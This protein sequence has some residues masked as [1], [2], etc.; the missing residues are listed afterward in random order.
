MKSLK[1]FSLNLPEQKYHEY[2]AW[3]YSMIA[4]YAKEGFQS[5]SHLHEFS[6]PTPS[7]EFGSLF[8]SIITRGKSTLDEYIVSDVTAPDAEKKV[9]EYILS[10][11]NSKF[12]SISNE[13]FEEAFDETK[14]YGNRKFDTKVDQLSKYSEYYNTRASGKKVVSRSDW[15]EAI[16]MAKNFRSYAHIN[17]LFGTK[18]SKDVEYCYQLQLLTEIESEDGSKI[19]IKIMLDAVKVDHKAKTVQP[20]D[21]KTS[22]QPAYDFSENFI[23]YRYD[24]QASLYTFVLKKVLS[25]DNEYK[26]YTVLP[27]IFADISRSDKIPVTWTYDPNDD[28]QVNGLCYEINGKTYQYKNWYTLLSEILKYEEAKA[29]VP[30][31]VSTTNHNNLITALSK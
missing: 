29:V 22:F 20:I 17:D 28:S 12:E 1:E 4:K 5:L 6:K 30:A 9:F 13:L 19:P 7:M 10:R 14:Y 27:F 15:D 3:S 25:E 31:G 8:D 24:I 11:T 16:E 23:T 21:L 26:D 18:N 2:P